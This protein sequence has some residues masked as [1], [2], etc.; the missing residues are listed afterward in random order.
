MQIIYTKRLHFFLFYIIKMTINWE[1]FDDS[2]KKIKYPY[3]FIHKFFLLL[4]H[5]NDD[6]SS[7]MLRYIIKNNLSIFTNNPFYVFCKV[8]SKDNHPETFY[9]L[10]RFYTLLKDKIKLLEQIKMWHKIYNNVYF[11]NK[12]IEPQIEYLYKIKTLIQSNFDNSKGGISFGIKINIIKNDNC[13]KQIVIESASERLRNVYKIMGKHYFKNVNIPIYSINDFFNMEDNDIIK[14]TNY[15]FL[16]TIE[17]LTK[18]INIFENYNMVSLQIDNLIDP[19]F[20]DI[21]EDTILSDDIEDL[22]FIMI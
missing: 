19:Y 22:N 5:I 12:E 8:I 1:E 6:Y 14:Y 2:I 21:E 7:I 11:W 17:I 10:D 16:K 20:I 9:I 3:I 18:I 15:V 13:D 4:E